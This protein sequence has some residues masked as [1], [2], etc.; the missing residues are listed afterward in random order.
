M[1]KFI[2]AIAAFFFIGA[3]FAQS[4]V[5]V[6][7]VNTNTVISAEVVKAEIQDVQLIVGD[8]VTA[9]DTVKK[10]GFSIGVLITVLI[11]LFLLTLIVLGTIVIMLFKIIAMFTPDSIDVKL[12][13]AEDWITKY[14]I[15]LSITILNK[16]K[17][18]VK[19]K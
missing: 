10:T 16:I 12:Q 11:P 17:G 5:Y 3:L 15:K 1:K 8:W 9:I 4:P 14:I 6:D 7:G 2:I 13:K 18:Y 19:K